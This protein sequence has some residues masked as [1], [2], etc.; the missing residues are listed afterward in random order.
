MEHLLT[1]LGALYLGFVA[2][3][4][5]RTAGVLN[6]IVVSGGREI[7]QKLDTIINKE[8]QMAGELDQLKATVEAENTVI[9]SAIALLNG[10]KAA[11]DAA[12]AANNPQA[13]VDLSNEIQAKSQALA[14]AVTTNT[15]AQP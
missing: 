2:W 1:I 4:L 3:L 6:Q 11:L 12:I 13:L 9:D 15:P 14:A 5:A 7:T 10:L 8:V